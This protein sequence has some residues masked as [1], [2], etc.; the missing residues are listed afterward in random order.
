MKKSITRNILVTTLLAIIILAIVLVFVMV[1]FMD[2]LMD[3]IMLNTLQPMA[4]TAAQSVEGNLH[5]LADRFFLIRDNVALSSPDS[6][7]EDMES[8]LSEVISGIEFVWLGVYHTDG[9]LFAGT[10]DSPRSIA[11]RELNTMIG[12]TNNLVIEDTSAGTDGLE[13]AMGIPITS[14]AEERNGE[15][16]YHLVGS[17][18]YDV[19]GD[20][21][22]T[23]NLG[24]NS[25][26]FIIDRD[27]TIIA[28]RQ[29]GKVYSQEN[30]ADT[31]GGGEDMLGILALMEHGQ[32]GSSSTGSSAGASFISYSPIRGTH[33]SMG[34]LAPK[35]DFTGPLQQAISTSITLVVAFVIILVVALS[36]LIRKILTAPM[37]MITDNS[38]LLSKGRFVETLPGDITRRAD[39]VGQLGNAF[40]S[41]S[42]AVRGVVG[43]VTSLTR[44]AR[45]GM[46]YHRADPE[47]YQGAYHQI[48]TGIN[49]TLD[50]FCEHLDAIPNAV[51]LYNRD[52]EPIYFNRAMAR[53]LERH[54]EYTGNKTLLASIISSGQDMGLP[55]A[56]EELFSCDDCSGEAFSTSV[57]IEEDNGEVFNYSLNLRRVSARMGH[58]EGDP[59]VCVM[60][61]LSDVTQLARAKTEAEAS[62]RAKTAFLA[63]MSHEI[64][65]P[66]NAIIGMTN[67]AKSTSSTAQKDD[68]LDKI[69]DASSHLLGVINDILDM[70][71]IEAEKFELSYADF[72]FEKMLQRLANVI[73]FRVDEKKQSFVVHIDREIPRMLRGDDQR[74]A[75]VIANLLSNAVKF[76]PEG[77]SIRLDAKLLEQTEGRFLLQIA[78]EDNGIGIS[79]EQREKLFDAFQQA[80]SS[81]SRK[82]GGTGLGLV[83]SRRIIEMMGGK[84]SVD[85]K[86]GEGSRFAFDV[87]L[88]R[89]SGQQPPLLHSDVNWKNLRIMAVDDAAEV[90]EHFEEVASQIEVA[91][92][93]AESGEHARG[94]IS[95]NGHYDIYFIDWMMPGMNGIELARTI[96]RDNGGE[97]KPVVIM[98]SS[99]AWSQIE[100]EAREAGVDL[101]LPKPLFPSTLVDCINQCMGVNA[102]PEPE[103]AEE[104]AEQNCFAGHRVLL[105]EDVEINR[106]IVET[107]LE[108]TGLAIDCAENGREAV[109]KFSADPDGYDVILM[110]VQMPEMD[111]YEATRTI[112]A[113]AHPRA[114]TIPIV[115]MTANVF[116][117]DVERCLASGMN[118]HIGKP[119]DFDELMDKLKKYLRRSGSRE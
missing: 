82:Y 48:V 32:T 93:V 99:V 21:L 102:A 24:A 59:P 109:E 15:V 104:A 20:V 62:S 50:V 27:G 38:K 6:G 47:K 3:S 12:E 52:K 30:I 110:D 119:V 37:Q 66:M 33:W 34:I 49:E 77:G 95:K 73:N 80:D 96:K 86:L 68:C 5:V 9:T 81:T 58:A 72:D 13:I 92:D 8:A 74:L 84:I 107:C 85:S 111:G 116:K 23:I 35:S 100:E 117:E 112:R 91:C 113:M 57:S 65:T 10:D 41:V 98:I 2:S 51:A 70:S 89:A 78:V 103:G 115:A 7:A 67:I 11:G 42:Q 88:E 114:K 94:L 36:F 28:H 17:Y 44:D 14:N 60:L 90:R 106:M 40:L 105:T 46:L 29:Q 76:T 19:L 101:F 26:A 43:D 56:V 63:N 71:K 118:E 69:E 31:L 54:S 25:T 55:L 87:W 4:K 97:G 64:R 45:A 79:A 18:R 61:I 1:F 83:I 75:Q 39:E 53:V 16:L 22:S 108:P